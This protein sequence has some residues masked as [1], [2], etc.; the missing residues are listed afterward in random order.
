M[1]LDETKSFEAFKL[2]P[3]ILAFYKNILKNKEKLVLTGIFQFMTI[4]YNILCN[5]KVLTITNTE[6]DD[7]SILFQEQLNPFLLEQVKGGDLFYEIH[8]HINDQNHL[9]FAMF[10][11]IGAEKYTFL[12][13]FLKHYAMKAETIKEIFQTFLDLDLRF[14]PT[15][16]SYTLSQMILQTFNSPNPNSDDFNDDIKEVLHFSIQNSLLSSTESSLIQELLLKKHS[17]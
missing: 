11:F 13:D 17:L 8:E 7:L 2:Y 14:D 3:L 15:T 1:V 12:I 6:L 4:Y 10:N 9:I 16:I 5:R